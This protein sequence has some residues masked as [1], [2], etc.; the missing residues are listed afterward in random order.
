M[1]IML[2]NPIHCL[3]VLAATLLMAATLQAESPVKI[4]IMAGQSNMQGKGAIIYE[5]FDYPAD[6][7]EPQSIVGKSGAIG[8]K[9]AY[10]YLSDTNPERAP[11]TIARGLGFGAL[12]VTGNRG[13]TGRWCE[14]TA[15]ELDDSLAKAGLLE[16]GATLWM[17]YVFLVSSEFEHRNGGGTITLRGE[18]MKEGLG[19][20][21]GGRQYET[22]VI[23][24][25]KKQ[26]RRIASSRPNAPTLVVAR[27]TWGKNGENDSFVPFQVG[28]DLKL[29]EKEG[30]HSAPF[31]IDQAKLSS[32]V[33]EGEGQFDEI[34]VGPTFESVIGRGK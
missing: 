13:G 32:L 28:P 25:G 8:T 9:G 4:Y 30:R 7:G 12:P 18:D 29:P 27:I 20:N 3:P 19:F 22:I 14:P 16:D 21:A 23:L 2:A 15:I 17:S 26:E 6:A 31:N 10:A 1:K 33:L 5:P 34:R 24:D 11:V